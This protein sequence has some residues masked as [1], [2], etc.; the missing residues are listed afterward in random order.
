MEVIVEVVQTF[1]QERIRNS[2]ERIGKQMV[3]V[4]VPQIIDNHRVDSAC[5][6]PQIKE[7]IL[8]LNFQSCLIEAVV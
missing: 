5:A 6:V 7:T 2:A 8:K 4:E 1:L 3:D